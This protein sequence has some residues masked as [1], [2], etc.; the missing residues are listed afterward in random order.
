MKTVSVEVPACS[1]DGCN[2]RA[3]WANCDRCGANFCEGHRETNTIEISPGYDID[4]YLT[5][6]IKPGQSSIRIPRKATVCKTGA[7]APEIKKLSGIYDEC[8]AMIERAGIVYASLP[9]SI[10]AQI[11]RANAGKAL[12]NTDH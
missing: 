11:E 1:I 2:E 7:C 9:F 6:F 12:T 4:R 3:G 8:R 10:F 5:M